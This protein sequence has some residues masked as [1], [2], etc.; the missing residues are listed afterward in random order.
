MAD[1]RRADIATFLRTRDAVTT[2]PVQLTANFRTAEPV[3]TWINGVFATLISP[4]PEPS[5]RELADYFID[6]DLPSRLPDALRPLLDVVV[7]Q[8]FALWSALARGV[9]PD[10]PS[11][12]GAIQ[13]VVTRIRPPAAG[14]RLP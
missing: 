5:A 2:E 14:E 10:T 4:E 3:V 7:G 9:R 8:M 6:L 11:P 13:R 1:F 12:S